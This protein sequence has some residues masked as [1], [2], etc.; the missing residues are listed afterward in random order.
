MAWTT[1]MPLTFWSR[2]TPTTDE[3]RRIRR[4]ALRAKGCHK[5]RISRSAG[6]TAS[7]ISPSWRS[8]ISRTMMMPNRVRMSP[9]TSIDDSS[10]S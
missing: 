10:I 8:I 6:M 4:N 9:I 3:F 7:V 5:T 1:R 2:Y